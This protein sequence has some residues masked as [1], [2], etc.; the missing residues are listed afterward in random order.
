[1]KGL[2]VLFWIFVVAQVICAGCIVVVL[3]IFPLW[4]FLLLVIICFIIVFIDKN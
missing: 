3:K 2:R 4:V 1:M